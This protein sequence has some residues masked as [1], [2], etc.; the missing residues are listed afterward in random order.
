METPVPPSGNVVLDVTNNANEIVGN[1]AI[2]GLSPGDTVVLV[3]VSHSNNNNQNIVSSS[4]DVSIL[5]SQGNVVPLSSNAVLCF[6]VNNTVSKSKSC[7]GYYDEVTK[8]W[9]CQDKCLSSQ[10]SNSQNNQ[11]FCGTTDHFTSFAI[12]LTGTTSNCG[13]NHDNLIF[14]DAWKDGVLIGSIAGGIIFLLILIAL[15]LM[16]TPWGS[17]ILYGEEGLRVKSLRS[18]RISTS[19]GATLREDEEEIV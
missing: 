8:E 6:Q 2:N 9:V 12:L 4:F 7:L 19:S 3:P 16:F 14:K 5:D 11:N 13:N 17:R 10:K 1:V 18:N 15:F